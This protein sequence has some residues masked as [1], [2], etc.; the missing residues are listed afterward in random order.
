M[1]EKL[2]SV[3]EQEY[4]KVCGH[5]WSKHRIAPTKVEIPQD[6]GSLEELENCWEIICEE[7]GCPYRTEETP[8][9]FESIKPELVNYNPQE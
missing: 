4:C 1:S 5:L 2:E 3:T 9:C 7:E 8:F 6:D